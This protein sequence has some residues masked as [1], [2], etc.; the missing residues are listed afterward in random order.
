VSCGDG[1]KGARRATKERER[2][3]ER[4]KEMRR[5]R[6]WETLRERTSVRERELVIIS[7]KKNTKKLR[8]SHLQ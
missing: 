1:K 5:E 4:V 7:S 3:R 8:T 6:E 2:E